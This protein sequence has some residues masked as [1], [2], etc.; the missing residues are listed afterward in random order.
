MAG[1]KTKLAHELAHAVEDIIYYSWPLV[2]YCIQFYLPQDH[3]SGL[4]SY[5][6]YQA[7]SYKRLGQ[8]SVLDM[9]F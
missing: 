4:G 3:L 6:N 9:F 8:T 7:L 5:C 2:P 1:D